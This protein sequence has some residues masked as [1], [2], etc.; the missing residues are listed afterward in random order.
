M[1][2]PQFLVG[3]FATSFITAIWAELET[4][5]VWKALGW[6][7]LAMIILQ[8]GY[9]GL[10]VRLIYRGG[11]QATEVDLVSANATPPVHRARPR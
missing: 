9:V 10:V 11:S 1:Y 8:V 7:V 4:G 2:F 3:M 5:S 6:A